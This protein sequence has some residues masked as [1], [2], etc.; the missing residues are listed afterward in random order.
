MTVTRRLTARLFTVLTDGHPVLVAVDDAQWVD[1]A[2]W[3]L[4]MELSRTWPARVMLFAQ[5]PVERD[6][7]EG[8]HH[9]NLAPL[10][11]EDTAALIGDR[12]DSDS[13][14]DD[15]VDAVWGRAGG[16]PLFTEEILRSMRDQ[17]VVT[18]AGPE[19]AASLDIGRWEGGS[20]PDSIA[21]SIASRLE[22][23]E[24]AAQRTLSVASVLG[25]SFDTRV[26][27]AI[28]PDGP[29]IGDVEGSLEWAVSARLVEREADG[30][31]RFSHGVI[32][33]VA[34]SRLPVPERRHLHAAAADVFAALGAGP[35][36][37]AHHLVEAGKPL[38]ALDP[39]EAAGR[40]ALAA[41][42]MPTPG[43]S[44]KWRSNSSR[45]R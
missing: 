18:V 33:E 13:I 3:E 10:G 37:I 15:L 12:L 21:A 16:H 26:L 25:S 39:L 8:T 20:L 7:P 43:R 22:R 34:A 19:R 9:L 44:S 2:T 11:R 30:T 4:L 38:E 5:R 31:T 35:A 32:A 27:T 36:L 17:G 23:L 42:P 24:P 28:H 41:R 40:Q 1:G 29:S 6:W 45:T 14:P